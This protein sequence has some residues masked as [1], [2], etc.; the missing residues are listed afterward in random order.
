MSDLLYILL[1]VAVMCAFSV[2]LVW[3]TYAAYYYMFIKSRQQNSSKD[4]FN[5]GA[6][7]KEQEDM[8]ES[9]N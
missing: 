1:I 6:Q 2:M 9:N 5:F 7:E 8:S 3:G 4:K